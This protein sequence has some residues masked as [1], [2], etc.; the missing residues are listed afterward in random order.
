[1]PDHPPA[2]DPRRPARETARFVPLPERYDPGVSPEQAA[3]RFHQ[4]M[5][6]RRSVRMFSDEPV[7]R[8]TIEW[9]VRA[10]AEG[11]PSGANKQPW[12]FVCVQN[13]DLKREIRLAAEEE[14]RQFYARRASEQWLDDLAPLGVD[15][16]KA[17]LEVAPWLIVVFK[18]V[19]DDDE[20]QVYYLNES[21]GIACGVLLCAIHHAG[22]CALTHTPSPMG[23][24]T[25]LLRRPDHERPFLLIPVG[26]P[27]EHCQVPQRALQRKPLDQIMVIDRPNP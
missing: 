1:M 4:V 12:R 10:A 6:T 17:F 14:E 2:D 23:F 5:R 25:Q 8:Q 19:R 18:L 20:G 3:Q 7:S 11:A 24:L 9:C 16:H 22:L 26:R 15:E 13:P 27:A 21:V